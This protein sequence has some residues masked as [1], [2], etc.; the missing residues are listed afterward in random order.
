MSCIGLRLR[1]RLGLQGVVLEI[2]EADG[3]V[4]VNFDT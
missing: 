1:D 4:L 2:D 3:T